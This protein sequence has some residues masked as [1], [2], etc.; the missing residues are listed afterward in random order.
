M[1]AAS[2]INDDG[3]LR[4]PM[5]WAPGG[6]GAGFTTSVPYRSL[7]S[8]AST[9]NVQAQQ[10]QPESLLAFYKAM[11]NLRNTRLSIARGSYDRPFVQGSV[12][13]YTR[14]LGQERTLVLINYGTQAARLTLTDLPSAAV[15]TTLWPQGTPATSASSGQA[16]VEVP[17]RSLRVVDVK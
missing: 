12:M 14:T 4:T 17:A 16:E 11:L 6:P 15:L 3:R 13:G 1:A 9:N 10:A 8:N 2:G 7:S 5:S